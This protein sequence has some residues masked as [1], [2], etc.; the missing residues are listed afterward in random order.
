M[1]DLIAEQSKQ[2]IEAETKRRIKK[3]PALAVELVKNPFPLTSGEDVDTVVQ[4]ELDAVGE[5]WVFE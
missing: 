3:E 4:A 5:L 1:S 2:L